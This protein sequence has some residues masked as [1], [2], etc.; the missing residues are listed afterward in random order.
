MK[1]IFTAIVTALSLAA[2][3]IT[4][5]TPG[6][7]SAPD[8]SRMVSSYIP[9]PD[10]DAQPQAIPE[11]QSLE[12]PTNQYGAVDVN[13]HVPYNV[14]VPPKPDDFQ[15]PQVNS[16][17]S[18]FSDL[19][20]SVPTLNVRSYI[21]T[22]AN[23]GQI[24]ADYRPN[25]REAPASITKLMTLYITAQELSSGT[26]KLTDQVRVPTAAWA[27]GGSRMFLK[28]NSLVTVNE[29][30][31]GLAVVSGNDAAVTL[32][33]YIAGNQ[34]AFVSMMNSTA[35]DLDMTNTHYSTVMGL[36]APHLYTS[37]YDQAILTDHIIET[38]PQY[39]GWYKQKSLTYNNITQQSYNRLLSIY[40]DAVGM[41]T[42]STNEAGY[43]LVG[44]AKQ[45]DGNMYLVS[46]VMGA[47][48][49][50]ASASDSKALLTYGF[51]FFK[52]QVLYQA[53]QT[54]KQARVYMGS[55]RY[56]AVGVAKALWVTLPRSVD[57]NRLSA[58]LMLK[59]DIKAP[60]QKGEQVGYV[61]IRLENK[62]LKQAPAVA[63]DDDGRGGIFRRSY[64]MIAQWF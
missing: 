61:V 46:V 33:N 4:I 52:D 37:A 21:L 48:S 12:V 19:A 59:K 9:L 14:Q 56:V 5:A 57:A 16:L 27:T 13:A 8:G 32:A 53:G 22:S 64:D 34:D 43:S 51:R 49:S 1:G 15:D 10:D 3:S 42:G 60:I 38:Y 28:S 6:N 26:I 63:L 35:K 17:A 45:P 40:K 54:I 44:A 29:L 31:Q 20:P 11:N 23:S 25:R 50:N 47:T 18:Q 30:I 24:I 39:M 36:P 2:S 62:V 7:T 41:K 58:D 55:K